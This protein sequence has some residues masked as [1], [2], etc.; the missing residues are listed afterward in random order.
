MK[1]Y[2]LLFAIAYSYCCNANCMLSKLSIDKR[3][4]N[5]KTIIDGI[6][7]AQHS[8]WN[9]DKSMIYTVSTVTVNSILKG[10]VPTTLEIITPGGQLDGK[11]LVV[12]PSA[13]L[14]IGANG[15]FMLNENTIAL[16]YSNTYKKYEIYA[17]AQGFIQKDKTTGVYNDAF[18]SY[19]SRTSLFGTIQKTTGI[20][21]REI[22]TQT[23]ITNST[24]GGASITLFTPAAISAGTQSILTID[25]WGFGKRT[26]AAT[27]QFRD[28]NS[29]SSSAFIS[30]PDTNYILSW[31]DTEIRVLIPGASAN[32]QSG[33]GSGA[34]NVI[35]S[36]G[37]SISSIAPLTISYNQFEYKRNKIA[38]MN[39]NGLSGYTFTLN[40]DL[41]NN[42]AAKNSFLKALNQWQCK[43]GVNISINPSTT[44]TTCS[45][46]M[47]N[48]NVISF[49]TS[50]CPLP[51]GALAVTYSSYTLCANSPVIPDGID[52]IFSPNANFYFGNENTIPTT[53]YD[54]ESVALHELGHA[55]GQG[56]NSD[57]NE[58]MYPSIANGVSKRTLNPLS[59]LASIYDVVTRST[60]TAYC[61]FSKHKAIPTA[62][63]TSMQSTP[64]T[65]AFISDKTTGCA[66]LTVNFIDK[67]T[68]TPTIW[69]WDINNDGVYDYT[70]QNPTHT[71]STPGTYTVK[72]IAQNANAK[73]TIIKTAMI[74]VAAPIKLTVDAV[75]N[76]SCNGNKNGILKATATGGNGVYSYNWSNMQ[77]SALVSNI[78]AGNYSVTATDG[79]N[80]T[81]TASKTLTQ[82][83]KLAVNII[84]INSFVGGTYSATID[85]T[86]GI[87]PYNYLLNNQTLL[88]SNVIS[89]LT[90][91]TYSLFVKDKNNCIQSASFTVGNLGT[92]TGVINAENSFEKID[93]YPNPA[94]NYVNL[95]LSLKEYKDVK[96]DLYDL[97]GQTVF[98][99]EYNSVKDK[100]TTLDLSNMSAGTYILKLSIPE[101]N[102]FRKIIV[103]K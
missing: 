98:Q 24:S 66:P 43:T 25:G 71:F 86:G 28:A 82:P 74:T 65:S 69:K 83:E 8:C 62:C 91:G 49:A 57:Y 34:F 97:T 70:T 88:N 89:D 5:S 6:V 73:D 96:I 53:Q 27:V 54:F 45:N 1:P 36:N 99:E 85:V 72:L 94:A 21:Y 23:G 103:S 78:T 42:T 7:T 102:A 29:I 100:Q 68:G 92:T 18:D 17:L 77:T 32:R 76:I 59:D 16:N 64:I 61:G 11:L 93:V 79:F 56:H 30:L 81:A 39:Q 87:E 95:N 26:G 14:N 4:Q 33:A 75:Q 101:G 12:E 13:D 90:S 80:C 31:T 58:I 41:N 15:I 38:L 48:V 3:V 37:V 22:D 46:Q 50:A 35:T 19:V 10:S 47:D 60:T 2:L 40:S 51:A 55:F 84:P 44:S 20:A 67:S 52:M 9:T 63:T